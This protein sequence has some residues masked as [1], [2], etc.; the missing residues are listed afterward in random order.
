MHIPQRLLLSVSP[1]IV[2]VLFVFELLVNHVNVELKLHRH[3]HVHG[4]E[5]HRV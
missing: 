4:G 5:R 3:N 1:R 2:L